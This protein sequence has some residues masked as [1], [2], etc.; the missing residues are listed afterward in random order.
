VFTDRGLRVDSCYDLDD[1]AVDE[2]EA[3]RIP[4]ERATGAI[5]LLAGGDNHM[6]PSAAMTERL[7]DTMRKHGREDDISSVTVRE[8]RS[9]VLDGSDGPSLPIRRAAVRLRRQLGGRCRRRR[10]MGP[11]RPLPQ[12]YVTA[13]CATP[14]DT[15]S[16]AS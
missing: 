12:H 10:C 16:A 3:A 14:P 5:L 6:W 11:D 2:I 1:Y 9:C 13:S 8:R 15:D 4:L 7:V